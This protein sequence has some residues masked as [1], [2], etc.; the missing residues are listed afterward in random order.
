M[1][2]LTMQ[3]DSPVSL[4]NV[5]S[6]VGL[7]LHGNLTSQWIEEINNY[8]AGVKII[9]VGRLTPIVKP[10]VLTSQL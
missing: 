1:P 5:E 8:C 3:I 10:A 9:L 4:E 2:W 7:D 6:E